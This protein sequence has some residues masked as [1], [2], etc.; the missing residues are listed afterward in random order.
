MR[1][2]LAMA[3]NRTRVNC[4]LRFHLEGNYANHYTTIAWYYLKQLFYH[5]ESLKN[6]EE[7]NELRWPRIELG[8]IATNVYTWKATMLTTIPPPDA[9]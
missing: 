4:Y 6:Y 8:S 3:E 1:G 2:E 9:L 5:F 7:N